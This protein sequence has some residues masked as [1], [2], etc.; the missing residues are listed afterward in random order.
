MALS[1]ENGRIKM[2]TLPR[3]LEFS[4]ENNRRKVVEILQN[5]PRRNLRCI[6]LGEKILF[7]PALSYFYLKRHFEIGRPR[8]PFLCRP[9]LRAEVLKSLG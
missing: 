7:L 6:E 2:T 8:L 3:V 9:R 1:L 5:L 4:T